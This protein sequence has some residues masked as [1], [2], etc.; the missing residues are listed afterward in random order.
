MSHYGIVGLRHLALNV[1][2]VQ[3]SKAFYELVFEMNVVWQP[4]PDNVYLSSGTDNLALHQIPTENLSTFSTQGG[5]FLDHL[6]FF[7]DSPANVDAMFQRVQTE[8]VP[9]VKPLKQH[10]DGSYSFYLADPDGNVIQV[11]YEPT[12]CK[13]ET[14]NGKRETGNG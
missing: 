13:G 9:I 1:K 6:G 8:G 14:I 7:I 10:R 4:D 12:V 2:D 5:Q 11:L 3:R